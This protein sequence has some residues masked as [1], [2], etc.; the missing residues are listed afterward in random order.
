MGHRHQFSGGVVAFHECRPR[1]GGQIAVAGAIHISVRP[2]RLQSRL[3]D[4]YQRIHGTLVSHLHRGQVRVEEGLGAGVGDH[5]IIDAL[6]QL[7]IDGLQIA[8][9]GMRNGGP[10]G[11]EDVLGQPANDQPV[12]VG[13]RHPLVHPPTRAHA[14]QAAGG[15]DQQRARPRARGGCGR[16]APGRPA[17]D[18]TAANQIDFIEAWRRNGIDL[19][20]W[21]V[22]AGWYPCGEHWSQV[23]T[24]EPD[25]ARFPHGIQ[26]V[27][28]KAHAEEMGLILWFE[29][30][31]VS[32]GSW[33]AETHPEW[34]LQV[35]DGDRLLNLG[36]PA[37]REWLTELIDDY[38]TH[39]GLDLYRQDF[40]IDPLAFWRAADAP[41]RQG[42][43]ENLYVQGYLA[44]FDALHR[45][46]PDLVIDTCSSGG[47]RNDL[48]TLRRAVILLRSD[49]QTPQGRFF[50]PDDPIPLQVGN[51]GH[52]YGLSS[53]VPYAN[54]TVWTPT[55][56]MN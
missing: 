4:Q 2:H 15:L 55:R 53:W 46:H 36:H 22:D 32:H 50:S 10:A 17:P 25:A 51:Q 3:V 49:Y 56:S 5:R 48:E 54:C 24:W 7:G 21:W 29:P 27:A 20:Y 11:G 18:Q 30:E 31:R 47:R 26:A 45:R 33:M 19:D 13:E 38:L 44:F 41:G 40:N 42:M 52:T 14:A 1:P 39:R 35:T 43:T 28:E 6:E 37:A 8:C 12:P 16:R 23:G 9:R 34:C